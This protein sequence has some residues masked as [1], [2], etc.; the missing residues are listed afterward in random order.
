MKIYGNKIYYIT[1][2]IYR[3]YLMLQRNGSSEKKWA[4]CTTLH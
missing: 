3:V 1:V 2:F 4:D